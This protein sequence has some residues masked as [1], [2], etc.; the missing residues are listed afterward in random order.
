[1]TADFPGQGRADAEKVF[2]AFAAVVGWS[3]TKQGS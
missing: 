2:A 3:H 1:M